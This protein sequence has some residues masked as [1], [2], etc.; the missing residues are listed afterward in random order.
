MICIIKMESHVIDK[1]HN[2]LDNSTDNGLFWCVFVEN[3]LEG[4]VAF[5][6]YKT[7]QAMVL[8]SINLKLKE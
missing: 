6:F 3:F 4:H 2:F 1:K 7:R 8:D 5:L